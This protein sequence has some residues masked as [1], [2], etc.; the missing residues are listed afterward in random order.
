MTDKMQR[1]SIDERQ[2]CNTSPRA[3]NLLTNFLSPPLHGYANFS[4]A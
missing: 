2:R 3:V 4:V 1:V